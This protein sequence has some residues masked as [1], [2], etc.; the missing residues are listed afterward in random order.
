MTIGIRENG[1]LNEFVTIVRDGET[2][3]GSFFGMD[4]KA[5]ARL[6][7]YH[8]LLLAVVEQAIS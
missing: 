7:V 4:Y 2:A 8:A 3:I 1:L 5:N 6:P